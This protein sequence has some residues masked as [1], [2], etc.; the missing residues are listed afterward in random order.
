MPQINC[1]I[2]IKIRIT[3]RLSD[4]QMGQLGDAI[5]RAVVGRIEF[6]RTIA[7][8]RQG[9]LDSGEYNPVREDALNK[10]TLTS[11]QKRDSRRIPIQPPARPWLIRK[12]INFHAQVGNFLD[13]IEGLHKEPLPGKIVYLDLWNEL[14][15]VSLWLVQVNR[16]FLLSELA[17]ILSKRAEEL[18]R[19]RSDQMLAY[20]LAATENLRQQL[21]EIDRDAVVR[22][23]IPSLA[24]NARFLDTE[25]ETDA[26][27]RPG[28]WILFSSMV[29]PRIELSN[30]ADLLIEIQVSVHLRDVTFLIPT[31]IFEQE[32]G[33]SWANYLQEFGNESAILRLQFVTARRRVNFL[34]L[35]YLVEKSVEARFNSEL[36]RPDTTYVG[37]LNLLNNSTL[38]QLPS[39]VRTPASSFT[40]D[41]TRGIDEAQATDVWEPN[42]QGAYIFALLT[43][44]PDRINA[45]RFRPQAGQIA[46]QLITMLDDPEGSKWAETLLSFLRQHYGSNPSTEPIPG[47]SA[48]EFLLLEL[49]SRNWFNRLF[50]AVEASKYWALHRLLIQLTLG[51]RYA[52]HARVRQTIATFNTQRHSISRHTYRQQEQEIWLDKNASDSAKRFSPSGYRLK[53]EDILVNI[54]SI[55]SVSRKAQR[56]KASRMLAFRQALEAEAQALF[57]RILLGQDT[58]QYNEESFA[59]A[60]LGAAVQRIHLNENDIEEVKI[61]RSLRLLGIEL[62][63]EEGFL[64]R[65]YI[66][67]ELVERVNRGAWETVAESRRTQVDGEFELLL[68][69]WIISSNAVVLETLGIGVS[70]IGIIAIAW[71]VGIV[72]LLIEAA[73]GTTTVLISISLSELIYIYKV[74][75]GDAKLSLEGF[76]IAALDGYLMALGFRGAGILGRGAAGLI[77]TTSL[78]R[79]IGGWVAE[80]LIVG[81]VGG[82]GSAALTTF[83][84]DLINVLSGRGSWSS[85]EDYVRQMAWGAFLGTV[86]EFGIGA[87]QPILRSGGETGL[88]TLTEVAAKIREAGISPARWTAWMTE[89]LGNLSKNFQTVFGEA[90][91]GRL[92]EAFRGRIGQVTEQLGASYRLG[93][94]R[95]VLELSPESLTRSSVEG[96][97]KF[98]NISQADL[99]NEAALAI[100]NR[101]H[102]TQLRTFLEA[103]NSLDTPILHALSKAGQLDILANSPYIANII[104]NDPVISH[105]LLTA[106]GASSEAVNR[107]RG[108]VALAR[109]LPIVPESLSLGEFF[110]EGGTSKLYEV[111]GRPD[112]LVKQGGG[113]LPVEAQSLVEL[114]LMGIDTVYAATR[115]IDGQTNIVVRRVDG[116]SSKDIIGRLR[117]PSRTPQNIEVVTQKTIDDLERIYR[118]L[119][120]NQ[121]NVGDFQFIVRR[122]DGAVFVNDP[123]SVTRGG[124]PSGNILNIIERFKAIWRQKQAGGGL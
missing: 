7:A 108:I 114:Q 79:L 83:S 21:I 104:R 98:L 59:R 91:S 53:R 118:T 124:G 76:L 51:T 18:S 92:L 67:Y 17:P 41:L 29:L 22:R 37:R 89:A 109:S 1:Y 60:V 56:I 12:A 113:R 57:K 68:Q 63:V 19:V 88:K 72:A 65:Y 112:L 100:L 27:L 20:G 75:F 46:D 5:A 99:S 31:A 11:Y 66:T 55:Y 111:A 82:A 78:E 117:Q 62:R 85:P 97:E 121:A 25:G 49:E 4:A 47:G 84:H 86:F 52:N 77:G 58:Q 8:G 24:R 116:V 54:D 73:G 93:I 107:I 38:G 69:G 33:L 3:G 15:W 70:I 16:E 90:M 45:A 30:F 87:L 115:R 123:V 101:L 44:S 2:P 32:Y 28:A 64:E 50:E 34:A 39:A 40:N 10:Y 48:F 74:V 81:T 80:R 119:Q 94:F 13:Y 120:Q 95:R 110:A 122:A 23:E 43:F 36:S 26:R 105:L 35:Q 96:L 14:R 106:A 61:E 9:I 42:W 103:L 71:E 102:A 6:A